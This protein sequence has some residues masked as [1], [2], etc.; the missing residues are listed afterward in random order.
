MDPSAI[1]NLLLIFKRFVKNLKIFSHLLLTSFAYTDIFHY[2]NWGMTRSLNEGSPAMDL[3]NQAV[4]L[5]R[6]G[7]AKKVG[8]PQF[9]SYE[10]NCQIEM[11]V[12]LG[13]VTDERFPQLLG[14]I[15]DRVQKAVD[16]QIAEEIGRDGVSATQPPAKQN[17]VEQATEQPTVI[18]PEKPFR[19]FLLAKS[20][21]LAVAPQGLVKHWY[22]CFVDGSETD[23]QKQGKALADLWDAGRVGPLVMTERLTQQPVV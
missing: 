15:Y 21:E 23:F 9:S 16:Q 11:S 22:K 5:V 4:V 12:D 10:A 8:R 20:Q 7:I 19:D 6:A 17:L 1:G 14:D 13:M 2:P 3:K 18:K